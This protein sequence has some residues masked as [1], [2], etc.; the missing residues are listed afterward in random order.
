MPSTTAYTAWTPPAGTKVYITDGTLVPDGTASVSAGGNISLSCGNVP[1]AT[2]QWEKETSPGVWTPISGATGRTYTKNGAIASDSGV[3]RCVITRSPASFRNSI[4]VT[5][6]VGSSHTVTFD[7]QGGSAVAAMNAIPGA[8]ITVLAVPTRPGYSFVGWYKEA[9]CVTPWDFSTDTVTSDIT[10]YAK[11]EGAG[12]LPPGAVSSIE[13]GNFPLTLAPGSFF[14]ATL[15]YAASGGDAPDPVPA[16]SVSLD[17]AS[18]AL[19]SVDAVSPYEAV[20]TALPQDPYIARSAPDNSAVYGEA[21]INFTA[22][23]TVGDT[24]HQK[25]AAVPLVI[26]DELATYVDASEQ[27]EDEFKEANAGLAPSDEFILPGN[28]QRPITSLDPDWVLLTRL[29]MASIEI[30]KPVSEVLPMCFE[31]ANKDAADI[32]IYVRGLV[33]D[34]RKALLPLTFSVTVREEI[35]VGIFEG[36]TALAERVLSAPLDCLDEIFDKIVIQ[37]E[38]RQGSRKGW[39]TRLVSGVLKPREAV[40]KGILE[41]TG[42][43]A[44]TLRLSY[45]VLDDEIL[46]AFEQDGYLIVPDGDNDMNIRDPI[47]VNTWKPG[48]APGDNTMQG[49]GGSGGSGGGCASGAAALLAIAACAAFVRLGGQEKS[50]SRRKPGKDAVFPKE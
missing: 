39:Y 45:Y 11:W 23:Q 46:E 26:A 49:Q 12:A 42:G 37:K 22:T 43:E 9:A 40:D 50:L 17:I 28:A 34:G 14:T 6:G 4:I 41:V 2:Y 25:T 27:A 18:A 24:T 5:V 29:D 1:G 19:V 30:Q 38:I 32:D 21:V 13:I 36:D 47:W 3:Y 10:L 48:Y 35:L 7:S 20:V 16:L 31:H 15:D 44:L 8:T 33:P